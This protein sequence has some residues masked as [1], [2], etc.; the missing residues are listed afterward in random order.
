MEPV[1][2]HIVLEDR[3]ILDKWLGIGSEEGL[4]ADHDIAQFLISLYSSNSSRKDD[5]QPSK[6]RCHQCHTPLTLYCTTCHLLFP[7]APHSLQTL[8]PLQ[9]LPPASL[10]PTLERASSSLVYL[11][12]LPSHNA[13]SEFN[14]IDK[15]VDSK[16]SLVSLIQAHEKSAQ[17]VRNGTALQ[18]SQGGVGG[19]C[20]SEAEDVTLVHFDVE[21]VEP[22]SSETTSI[23]DASSQSQNSQSEPS[24][25]GKPQESR[26]FNKAG[27]GQ[28]KKFAAKPVV[29]SSRV[30][31]KKRKRGRPRKTSSEQ[32]GEGLENHK[33][34][35]ISLTRCDTAKR[36]KQVKHMKE[37]KAHVCTHCHRSYDTQELLQAHLRCNHGP[38]VCA[39]CGKSYE[40]YISYDWHI[41]TTS[42]RPDNSFECDLCGFVYRL[43]RNLLRHKR[44]MHSDNTSLQCKKC[45]KLCPTMNNLR[46]HIKKHARDVSGN[47]CEYC[48]VTIKSK[49]SMKSHIN[50]H[51]GEKPYPCSKCD[52]SFR[53]TSLRSQHMTGHHA[54]IEKPFRCDQC[55]RGFIKAETLKFHMY[56]HT[57]EKPYKCTICPSVFARKDYLNKHMRTHT[58]E[59]P[60][61]CRSC[62]A[63]FAYPNT[64]KAHLLK[65]HGGV[66]KYPKQENVPIVLSE[67]EPAKMEQPQTQSQ[68]FVF[69]QPGM[70]LPTVP[71]VPDSP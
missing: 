29:C 46:N 32:G 3:H 23:H 10:P 38:F 39:K 70:L 28:K 71:S 52:K 12:S 66:N 68:R 67:P 51:R 11:Q 9:A 42:C 49:E 31:K 63:K 59:R 55:D 25:A 34:L 41:R 54:A 58:G 65:Y 2:Q 26:T 18:E 40:V 30:E 64:L 60:Y 8:P 50:M 27:S 13:L 22:A 4:T 47:Q 69:L 57:G 6:C 45:G 33:S 19:D 56:S 43:E 24:R 16:L 61:K 15:D 35:K 48:G 53:S 17:A 20:S 44:K 21:K 36:G 37:T 62:D 5:T 14:N 1:K 7:D